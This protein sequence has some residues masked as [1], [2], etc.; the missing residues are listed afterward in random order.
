MS[1]PFKRNDYAL[2]IKPGRERSLQKRHPW[3]FSGAALNQPRVPAGALVE[4]ST[5]AGDFLGR[6]YFNP[7]SQ[8]VARVLTWQE[9]EG[10][11]EAFWIRRIHQ[12]KI[13]RPFT[14]DTDSYRLVFAEADG[15][16]GLIVD[17]YAGHIVI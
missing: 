10:V 1:K 5:P 13:I 4:I 15:V 3:V 17:Q 2:I 12:A 8:I 11:D 9:D 7:R 16:P 14:D 6:G